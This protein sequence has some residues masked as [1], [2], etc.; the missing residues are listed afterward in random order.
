[1][2]MVGS[3]ANANKALGAGV[4]LI[5]AQG[6]EA[7]GHTGDV[8]SSVLWP[9]VADAC[10]GHT[11]PLTGEAVI[12]VAAGGVFDGRSLATALQMGCSG[13]WVGS[14]GRAKIYALPRAAVCG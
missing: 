6:T 2:N 11:S 8:A 3:V 12:V 1:M 7:G 10:R 14:W 4:D 13:V 9:T 5:C